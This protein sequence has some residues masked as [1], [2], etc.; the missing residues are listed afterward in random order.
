MSR[1]RFLKT[2]LT[3]TAGAAVGARVS[4]APAF[5]LVIRGGTVVDGTGAPVYAADVALNG[6]AIAAVGSIGA[7]QKS[8]V[9]CETG[10]NGPV[11]TQTTA[12]LRIRAKPSL[13]ATVVGY[14]QP[15]EQI[16]VLERAVIGSIIWVRL[17]RGWSV[18]RNGATGE[19]YLG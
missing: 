7:E 18:G 3:A 2:T 9:G 5:D 19:I 6:D 17:D 16:T 10:C 1:R 13:D 8:P 12:P 15:G 11:V 14:L 4:A